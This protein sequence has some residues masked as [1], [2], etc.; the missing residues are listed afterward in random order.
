MVGENLKGHNKGNSKI[1]Q[2][3]HLIFDHFK[4]R[5][6]KLV[7]ALYHFMPVDKVAEMLGT[8][9]KF[10]YENY[11]AIDEELSK[12]LKEARLNKRKE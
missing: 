9:K 12:K 5:E 2:G 11:G 8:S 1:Y 6:K 10:L 3:I 7:R 4:E